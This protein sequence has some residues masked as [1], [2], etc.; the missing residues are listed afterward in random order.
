[1]SASFKLDTWIRPPHQQVSKPCKAE[2]Q[3]NEPEDLENHIP[4]PSP[5]ENQMKEP[6]VVENHQIEPLHRENRYEKP[7]TIE[8][9]FIEPR[10]GFSDRP[11][12]KCWTGCEC[13]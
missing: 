9:Q 3:S 4:E 12:P 10:I 11:Y 8:N 2:N 5:L 13:C 6:E 1:M 7:L